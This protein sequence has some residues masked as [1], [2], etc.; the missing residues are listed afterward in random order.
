MS[1]MKITKVWWRILRPYRV[2][3]REAYSKHQTQAGGGPLRGEELQGP[4][5]V[6]RPRVQHF[7]EALPAASFLGIPYKACFYIYKTGRI[8]FTLVAHNGRL[9]EPYTPPPFYMARKADALMLK[10][11]CAG[12]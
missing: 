12:N 2:E 9:V 3:W 11:T 4:F 7:L 10:L 6:M 5:Y 1:E 8:P